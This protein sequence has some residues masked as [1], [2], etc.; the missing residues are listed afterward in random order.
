MYKGSLLRVPGYILMFFNGIVDVADL[1][2]TSCFVTYFHFT[3][4]VFCTTILLE[5]VSGHLAL[6]FWLGV[7]S[8]CIVLAFNR[9][10]FVFVDDAFTILYAHGMVRTKTS[11]FQ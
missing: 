11:T 6:G 10:N 3:G 2:V 1:I 9:K 8:N 4:A 5:W 7:S